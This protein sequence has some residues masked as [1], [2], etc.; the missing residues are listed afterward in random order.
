[1][2]T[3]ALVSVGL[4]RD[5]APATPGRLGSDCVQIGVPVAA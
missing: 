1:M 5:L 2:I 4:L 3:S